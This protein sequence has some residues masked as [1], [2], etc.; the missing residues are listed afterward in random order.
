MRPTVFY[1]NQTFVV[2][3][4]QMAKKATFAALL[5]WCLCIETRLRR[6]RRKDWRKDFLMDFTL[7]N[8]PSR[9][10]WS[11]G[12]RVHLQEKTGNMTV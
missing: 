3:K 1:I 4:R 6:I 10:T 9:A 2:L 5:V 8:G 7:D 12:L 11:L